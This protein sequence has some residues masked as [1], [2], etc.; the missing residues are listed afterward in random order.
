VGQALARADAVMC[1]LI[2]LDAMPLS[3][4]RTASRHVGHRSRSWCRRT[5]GRRHPRTPSTWTLRRQPLPR[6]WRWNGW[7]TYQTGRHS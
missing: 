4:R 6:R 2:A 7:I 5:A 3:G 1:A